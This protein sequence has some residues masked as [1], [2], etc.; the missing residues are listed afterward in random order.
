MN[1]THAGLV[2][3]YGNLFGKRFK[4]DGVYIF[5]Q[6]F[7]IVYNNDG[8]H[9]GLSYVDVNNNVS[10]ALIECVDSLENLGYRLVK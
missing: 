2:R 7:G 3:E 5:Y 10:F 9:Y 1:K 8:V 6:L 4:E